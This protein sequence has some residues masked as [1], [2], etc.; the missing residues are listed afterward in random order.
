MKQIKQ[1]DRI[2]VIQDLVVHQDFQSIKKN[3]K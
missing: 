3:I 1:E 2:S